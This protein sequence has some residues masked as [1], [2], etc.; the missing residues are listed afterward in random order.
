M[1]KLN[2]ELFEMYRRPSPLVL[3][4]LVSIGWCRTDYSRLGGPRKDGQQ[5]ALEVGLLEHG[6]LEWWT[7]DGLVEAGPGSVLIDRPGDHQ[8][9]MNAIVH[10]CQRYWIRFNFPQSGALPGLSED[11]TQHLA[12]WFRDETRRHFPASPTHKENFE[13]LLNLQREPGLFAEEASRAIF[14]LILFQAVEDGE[15]FEE[16]VRS[17]PVTAAIAY[18]D[19]HLSSDCHVEEVA[20]HVGLSVGYFHEL[21][22]REVGLT[23]SQYHLRKRVAAAKHELIYSDMSVT[24]LATDIGFSSSQYFATAFRKVVGLTPT[25]YRTLRDTPRP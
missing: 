13:R 15:R 14:H 3:P 24:A 20:R 5:P 16:V 18:F 11:T 12:E 21:F 1:R 7:E 4:E 22:V 25:E 6:S 23:P 9:G 8:G 17:P 10:P 2:S 19:R